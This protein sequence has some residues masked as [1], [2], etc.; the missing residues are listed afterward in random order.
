[1]AKPFVTLLKG[2]ISSRFASSG[3]ILSAF[4]IFDPRKVPSADLATYGEDAIE[5]LLAHYSTNKP[6]ETLQGEA[7]TREGMISQEIRTEWKT[8]RQFMAKQPKEDMKLQMRELASN[9]ML[10]T[11]FP[12]L[13]RLA[14]ISF[15]I[16]VTTASVE[17]SFSKMKLVKTCL[18]SC[19]SDTSLLHLMKIAIESPNTLS[20]EELEQTVDVWNRKG[21]RIAV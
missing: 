14:V 4:S 17:R 2:N 18:Q 8:F 16:S 10:I 20:D 15:S 21:R 6:A 7:T 3:A 11:V 5:T 1:M 13:S 9:D 19:L 12:N